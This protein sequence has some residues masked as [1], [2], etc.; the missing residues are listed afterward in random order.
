MMRLKSILQLL[1]VM[2]FMLGCGLANALPQIT[3]PYSPHEQTL[4]NLPPTP[5]G[6][7]PTPTGTATGILNIQAYPTPTWT[8]TPISSLATSPSLV[9]IKIPQKCILEDWETYMDTNG[10]F[11]FSIPPGFGVGSEGQEGVYVYG[12]ALDPSDEFRARAYFGLEKTPLGDN[13]AEMT[14]LFLE[15]FENM[16][17]PPIIRQPFELD[18]E[19]A[20]LLEGVPGLGMARVILV[21]QDDFLYTIGFQPLGFPEAQSDFDLLFETI[22]KSFTYLR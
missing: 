8:A 16:D 15:E 2:V 18:G 21:Y 20:E 13:L 22:V 1:I 4:T 14:D 11:C 19:P 12:P 6:G 17:I 10:R 3:E 7:F 5:I 9:E